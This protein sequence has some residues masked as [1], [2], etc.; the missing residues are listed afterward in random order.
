M[1]T[2]STKT[3]EI[4]E[5][6]KVK[7]SLKIGIKTSTRKN[8]TPKKETNINV[9]GTKA[10]STTNKNSKKANNNVIASTRCAIKPDSV[11]KKSKT[12]KRTLCLNLVKEKQ[13][14]SN[15]EIARPSKKEITINKIS[16]NI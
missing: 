13:E 9:K 15:K 6:T 16:T 12:G 7:R 1:A 3:V 8:N 4:K 11:I 5:K 14:I 2:K 10:K